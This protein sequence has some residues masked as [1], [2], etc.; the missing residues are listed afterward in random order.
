MDGVGS[1]SPAE[2]AK[3]RA[4]FKKS[5]APAAAKPAS[6]LPGARVPSVQRVAI[7]GDVKAAQSNANAQT[8]LQSQ[9]APPNAVVYT[10]DD[11]TPLVIEG[12]PPMQS[13]NFDVMEQL[14]GNAKAMM[15]PLLFAGVGLYLAG[16]RSP[17][18]FG[19]M[20]GG[21]VIGLTG[22]AMLAAKDGEQPNG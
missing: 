6:V 15:Y 12:S 11:F 13:S 1:L 21:A 19:F 10:E 14:K 7:L 2:A 20:A 3:A 8:L 5:G 17:K 9:G 4:M 22:K 16:V 18:V